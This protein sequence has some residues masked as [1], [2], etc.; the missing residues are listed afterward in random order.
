MID[1]FHVSVTVWASKVFTWYI[2]ILAE[3]TSAPLP[4]RVTWEEIHSGLVYTT[5]ARAAAKPQSGMSA[6]G[7]DQ[8]FG[9]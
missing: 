3:E 1:P 9:S 7:Q 5:A 4:V 8:A 2:V 6:V